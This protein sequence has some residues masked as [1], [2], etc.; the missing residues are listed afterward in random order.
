[1]S[2]GDIERPPTFRET[3]QERTEPP[4]LDFPLGS[5]L[6]F[7]DVAVEDIPDATIPVEV[8]N[9]LP[10]VQPLTGW[11]TGQ[12]T[13]DEFDATQ[14]LGAN[15]NRTRAVVTNNDDADPVFLTDDSTTPTQFGYRLGFGVSL[16]LFHNRQVWAR[17]A[18]GVTCTV[19][20]LAEYII[21][22]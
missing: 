20:V 15:R 19:S 11:S 1:M 5:D 13:V 12:F 21:D 22:E 17:T 14:L 18:T 10:T 3:P 16:E 6:G 2:A 4:P 7:S 8:V 9:V